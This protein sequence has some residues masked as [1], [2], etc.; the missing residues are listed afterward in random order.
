MDASPLCPEAQ[1]L[2]DE[3]RVSHQALRAAIE[4]HRAA[5]V[6]NRR[7]LVK[8]H[9]R[10][11]ELEPGQFSYQDIATRLGLSS[12]EHACRQVLIQ[13]REDTAG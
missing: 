12:R 1:A 7:D 8:L 4:A 5:L 9:T 3:A 13:I 10:G 11:R 6:R 2:L